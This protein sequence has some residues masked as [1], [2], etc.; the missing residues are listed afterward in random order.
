MSIA[1]ERRERRKPNRLTPEELK[2]TLRL[3]DLGWT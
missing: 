3:R 1:E 2:G